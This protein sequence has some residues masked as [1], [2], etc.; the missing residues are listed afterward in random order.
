MS[1]YDLRTEAQALPASWRSRILG[2]VGATNLKVL[3]MDAHS[4]AEEMHVY[5]EGLLVIDGRLELSVQE[6]KIS[7]APGQLYIA[8]A[9]IPHTVE[10][11]SFGTLVI[12]DLPDS[13]FS[14]ASPTDIALCQER[15]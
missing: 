3:R 6:K 10:T 9:G 2:R 11:G 13:G 14:G 4:V 12:I 1:L 7:V 5:D 15:T 8:K